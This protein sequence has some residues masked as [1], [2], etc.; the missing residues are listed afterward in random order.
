ME[1]NNKFS[2]Q[3]KLKSRKTIDLLFSKGRSI[4]NGPVRVV[5]LAKENLSGSLVNTGFSVPKKNIKLAVNRNLLKRRMR[6]AYRLNNH[7]FKY[8]LTQNKKGLDIMFIYTS[9]QI[10]TYKEI[11]DKI[12]VILTRLIELSEMVGE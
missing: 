8:A 4:N 12:K 2:K 7:K 5:F 1:L 11:E 3:E 9:K 10:C 6:E